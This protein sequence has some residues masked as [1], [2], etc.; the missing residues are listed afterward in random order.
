MS[1]AR[2]CEQAGMSERLA[3]FL[4]ADPEGSL[5]QS[6]VRAVQD[7]LKPL[8]TEGRLRI[9]PL[10]LMLVAISFFATG[11]FLFFSFYQP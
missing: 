2:D 9:N 1:E 4:A 5:S 6:L 3:C 10:L 8:T 11:T 7:P